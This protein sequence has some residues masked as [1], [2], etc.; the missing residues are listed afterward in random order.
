MV[1]VIARI[2][3]HDEPVA[4]LAADATS[5]DPVRARQELVLAAAKELGAEVQCATLE[6]V[7]IFLH[8]GVPF[9]LQLLEK[10]DEILQRRQPRMRTCM[11]P[12]LRGGPGR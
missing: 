7:K 12:H 2:N 9:N 3:G 4:M 1:R 10:N 11:F 6:D 8:G 5:L